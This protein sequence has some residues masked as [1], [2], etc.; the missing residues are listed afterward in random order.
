M[1]IVFIIFLMAVT[2]GV[3]AQ[4]TSKKREVQV[5]SSFKPVLKEAAKINFNASPPDVD[6][7]KPRLRYEIPNQNLLF[8]YQPGSLK[9]LALAIDTSGKW[10]NHNYVKLGY[11]SLN[12][13]YFEAGLSLGNGNSAGLNAYGQHVSSKGKIKYQDY[14][15]TSVDLNGFL[16]TSG[17]LELTGRF[18]A[19]EEKY[20]AYGYQPK[21][22]VIPVDSLRIK[23]QTMRSR[24]GLRN[25]NRNEAGISFAP[26]INL[27]IFTDIHDNHETIGYFN[28]PLRKTFEGR[29]EA[30][31]AAD[32]G[33]SNYA[34]FGKDKSKTNF[35][36]ISPSLFVKTTNLYIQAGIKPTW[37]NSEFKLFPNAMLE[38]SSTDKRLALIAGWIGYMKMNT[39][40]SMAEYN[41]WINVPGGVNNSQVQEAYAGLKGSVTDH[42]NYLAKAGVNT[43][44]NRPLFM[45]DTITGRKFNVVFEPE[46]KSFNVHGEMGYTMGEKFSFKAGATINKYAGLDLNAKPWGLPQLEFNSNIRIQILKDL[47]AKADIYAFDEVWTKT[48]T[49]TDKLPGGFDV[50]AGLEFRIVKNVKLWARFNNILNTPYER[51]K[52]YPVY[53]FNMLG[54]VVFSFAQNNK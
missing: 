47:Y 51:W 34:V 5:T 23:Y 21:T 14:T 11:G 40:Q 13:P 36:S 54:G 26:E 17:N 41:P 1:R 53:G 15:H 6:T 22:L 43:F 30:E 10:V 20:K 48:K 33:F 18:G 27:D 38:L 45:N 46:M 37:D 7:T 9:P 50:S 31:V 52:Q 24:F 29:F 8:A 44:T 19:K 28:V 42:F 49:A 25:I 3:F 4:D 16:H 12:T 39:Y 2:A 32:G 35:I